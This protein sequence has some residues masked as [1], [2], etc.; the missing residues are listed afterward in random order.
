MKP[1]AWMAGASLASWFLV[2]VISEGRGDPELL[3]GM[4]APLV[5]AIGSWVAYERA[6]RSAPGTLTNVMIA[7]LAVKMVL[8]GAY[9]IAMLRGFDLRPVPFVVS[10]AAYFIALHAME[11][12]FL[13]RLLMNDLRSP[14]REQA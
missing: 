5:S 10:F 6:H 7:A 4:A 14:S 13:R 12:L 3:F 11:A 1:V 8:F 9:F 2:R